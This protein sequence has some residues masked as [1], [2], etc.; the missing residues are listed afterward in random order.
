MNNTW[1]VVANASKCKIYKYQRYSNSLDC[2]RSID[3]SESRFKSGELVTDRYGNLKSREPTH[4]YFGDQ[5]NP[6][7]SE[8][9]Q[10]AK[11]INALL[12]SYRVKGKLDNLLIF[13]P[14]HFHGLL[15]KFRNKNIDKLVLK[16]LQKDYVNYSD[17]QLKQYLYDNWLELIH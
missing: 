11:E 8:K 6:I 16:D 5:I 17:L 12:E 13:A 1:I 2:H 9:I 3:H 7:E 15:N 10:F 14:P 4:G